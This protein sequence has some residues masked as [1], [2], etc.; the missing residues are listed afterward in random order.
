MSKDND[1]IV[2]NEGIKKTGR[3]GKYNFPQAVPPEEPE[4]VKRVLSECLHWYEAGT[5]SRCETDEDIEDRTLDFFRHCADIGE[6]PSVEKYCLALGYARNTVF[7]WEQG[8]HCTPRRSNI[9]KNAKSVIASY[10]AA[11]VSEGKM[12]P[13]PYIFRAKNFYSMKDQTDIVVEPKQSATYDL[14]E[15]E[16]KKFAELP[17]D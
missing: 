1:V 6:R 5:V 16:I 8:L 11:M 15:D 12:N 13:V 10:D 14:G 2:I 17:E 7:E 3:G 9:I 4:T